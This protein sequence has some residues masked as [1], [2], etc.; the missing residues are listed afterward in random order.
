MLI[1]RIYQSVSKGMYFMKKL[2]VIPARYASTRFPGKP[3]QKIAG[4][5][6]LNRVADIAQE[7]IKKSPDTDFIISTEDDRIVE[8]AKELGVPVVKTSDTCKNGTH[9]AFETVE[10]L[11]EKPELIVN[12]QGDAPFTPPHFV[13]ALLECLERNPDAG[14]ATVATQLTWEKL[15]MLR[16]QKELS[17]LSGT[18]VII[19]KHNQGIYFSKQII[20]SIRKEAREEDFSPVF[21]HIGLYGYRYDALEQFFSWPEGDYEK[22]EALEQLRFIENDV[23]VYVEKVTYGNRP[24]MSGVDS[25]EDLRLAERLFLEFEDQPKGQ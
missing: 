19:N 23:P 15:D 16:G 2:I 11:A 24:S 22:L 3:L 6:M 25:P 1:S 21:R 4:K 7:V 5:T 14:V 8:H 17:P 9:R 20:P 10:N 12:L 18:T 13:V